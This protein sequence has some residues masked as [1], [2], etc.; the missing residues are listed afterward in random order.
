MLRIIVIVV[1][2][3]VAGLPALAQRTPAPE[4]AEVYIVNPADGA[5]V[6]SPVTVVFGARGIGIAP[7]GIEAEQTGHHHLLVDVDL[8]DVDLDNPLPATDQIIHFGGG[9]TETTVELPAGSHTLMLLMADH[10]HV[11]HAPP[12]VSA[13]VTITVE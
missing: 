5:T 2:A 1:I 6:T 3:A 10:R 13:P 9:Q 4:G 12:L 7:A 8:E 11:P